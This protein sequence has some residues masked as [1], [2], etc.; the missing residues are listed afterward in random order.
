MSPTPNY[1]ARERARAIAWKHTTGA[2]PPEARL[3]APY[4]RVDGPAYDFCL[5]A[6]FADHA[7][8]PEVRKSMVAFF[9]ERE[10][11]WHRGPGGGV[12]NHLLSSQVQCV[13]ALGQMV[14]DPDR[15]LRAFAPVLG[16]AE[17]LPIE[18]DSYLTFEF[19]GDEDLL[20]E[21]RDGARTRGS[22]CTSVDAAFVHRTAED[23]MELVL[24]EWKYT[25]SYAKRPPDP[26]KDEVRRARYA[27]LLAD[28]DG[29]VRADLLPFSDLC[30]EPIYQLV[31]QQL[32]AHALEQ[33]RAFG[34]DR[35]RVLHV[36]PVANAA[37]QS[38]LHGDAVRK[39]GSNVKEVWSRLLRH[40]DR[41]VQVDSAMFLDPTITSREYVARYGPSPEETSAA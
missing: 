28:A 10:I 12:S 23:L 35:V 15:L 40:P 36:L 33:S 2:L 31:R 5:P 34:A 21:A 8:L 7:L 9:A 3:P 11:E 18:G 16:T 29:P 32:L 4:V 14:T 20:N 24:V 41:F 22:G 13:N 17:V 6:P 30:Q 1:I 19:I 25:E 26:E 39:L 37:Y 38:S 27:A